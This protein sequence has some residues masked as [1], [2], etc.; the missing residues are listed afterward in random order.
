M[1]NFRFCCNNLLYLWLYSFWSWCLWGWGNSRIIL[2][3]QTKNLIDFTVLFRA[4]FLNNAIINL[5]LIQ[6]YSFA[7]LVNRHGLCTWLPPLSKFLFFGINFSLIYLN[8]KRP[9]VS[10]FRRNWFSSIYFLSQEIILIKSYTSFWLTI[11]ILKRIGWFAVYRIA[12][13]LL[14]TRSWD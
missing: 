9:L 4:D 3:S 13:I 7:P 1:N 11:W 6:L 10:H 14:I 8:I 2:L 12:F 5:P